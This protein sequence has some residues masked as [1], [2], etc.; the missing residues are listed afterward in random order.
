VD[1]IRAAPG[2]AEFGV[3]TLLLAE[4]YQAGTSFRIPAGCFFPQPD[5]TSAC[6]RLERRSTPLV[7]SGEASVYRQLVKTAFSQRRKQL[8]KVLRQLWTEA[9]LQEAWS[10]E[11]LSSELR[12][13]VLSPEAFARLTRWLGQPA[14]SSIVS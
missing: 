9:K 13:E 6:I 11:G 12:A 7:S 1:R 10:A 3:L 8:R 2:T 14:V 5:V 4:N